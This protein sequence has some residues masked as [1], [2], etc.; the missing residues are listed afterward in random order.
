MQKVTALFLSLLL[1]MPYVVSAETPAERRARLEAQLQQVERQIL[2]QRVL[3]EQKQRERQSLERDLAIIDSEIKEAQLGIQARAV[4]IEQLS[5]QISE[6]EEIIEILNERLEKQRTSLAELIRQTQAIDDFSLAEILLSNKNFSEFFT[7][8]ES[9]RAVKNGLNNS[10]SALTE[11]KQDTQRQKASLEQKQIEEAKMKRAQEIEKANIE[12]QE[13]EKARILKVTKGQEEAYQTLLEAQQKTAAQLKAQ[14]FQLL[15]GGGAIPFPEA[16]RLAQVAERLTGTPASLILAI[17]EQESYYGRNIGSCTMGD[18]SAGRDIMHPTRDKPAFLAIAKELGF[19]PATQQVSCP[20]RRSD[21]SR[22][23]WGGAMGP[24]Q[25]IPSTWAIY[26]G[27][28]KDASG[29]YRYVASQ[30][31]IRTL[32]RKSTPGNP[33]SNQD[34]FLA[35]ALLLRDNGANGSYSADRLAALRYYAGW[36]GATRPENAFYGNGVMKRKARLE[37]E[38]RTLAGG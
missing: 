28:Q 4:A 26:G 30:D 15:G 8:V 18:V 13:A 22:I 6:K 9:F 1:L 29:N 31:A 14:L 12:A 38:I 36:G 23:G 34:A 11:I 21:G 24:S 17:L 20:L 16:V 33:Y 2:N 32:L 25:F 35:T 10:L 27:F 5:E 3:V 7:D 19:N 37:G